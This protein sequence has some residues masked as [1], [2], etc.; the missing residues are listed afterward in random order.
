MD[1]RRG[2]ADD[3]FF[4]TMQTWDRDAFIRAASATAGLLLAVGVVPHARATGLLDERGE[5]DPTLLR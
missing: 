2:V 1:E 5:M 3:R 4:T